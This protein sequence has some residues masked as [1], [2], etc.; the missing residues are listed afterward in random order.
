MD[1]LVS[2]RQFLKIILIGESGSGK[3]AFLRRFI[4]NT[5]GNDY[6]NTIGATYISKTIDYKDSSIELQFWDTA[7]QEKFQSLGSSFYRGADACILVYDTTSALS[8]SNLAMWKSEFL[9]QIDFNYRED[10]PFVVV[11]TKADLTQSRAVPTES[12]K[13]WCNNNSIPDRLRFETSAKTGE[14][15]EE[16]VMAAVDVGLRHSFRKV[17]YAPGVIDIKDFHEKKSFCC[18]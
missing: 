18:C 2:S 5:F 6:H 15:V 16:A 10:L 17:V 1:P 14:G 8:L 11:G 9:L 13:E 4:T 12:A 3:T 7:G